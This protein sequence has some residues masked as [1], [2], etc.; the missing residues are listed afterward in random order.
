MFRNHGNV[1]VS[2]LVNDVYLIDHEHGVT[3]CD[4]M[5]IV[6]FEASGMC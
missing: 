5:L 1:S 4:T 3:N 2:R 6:R